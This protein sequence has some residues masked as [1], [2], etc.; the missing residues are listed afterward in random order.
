[1]LRSAW[2]S[3]STWPGLAEVAEYRPGR[4][5]E[6]E[7]PAL[8]A[9]VSHVGELDLLVVDGYVDLDPTGR[10]GWVRTSTDAKALVWVKGRLYDVAAGWRSVPV[11]GSSGSSRF[12]GYGDPFDAATWSR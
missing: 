9:V 12:S 1:M 8:R 10:P 11:D 3:P 7:L 5:V 4:F 6:R 2:W